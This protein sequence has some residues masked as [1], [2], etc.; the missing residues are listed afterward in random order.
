MISLESLIVMACG[1]MSEE[2]KNGKI[3]KK[4]LRYKRLN[5]FSY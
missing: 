1:S 4:F 5:T 2:L 3:F